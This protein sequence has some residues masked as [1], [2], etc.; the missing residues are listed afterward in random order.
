MARKKKT[1]DY[2][3]YLKLDRDFLGIPNATLRSPE[4]NSLSVHSRWLYIIL[5]TKFSR[6]RDKAK[7]SYSFTYK[8]LSEITGF[9]ARRLASC[10]I[11]LEDSNLI[12]VVHGGKHNPSRYKPILKWLC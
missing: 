2:S 3:N 7:Q 1:G 6:D 9:D 11:D 12:D 4:L 10:I 5:L 8:E